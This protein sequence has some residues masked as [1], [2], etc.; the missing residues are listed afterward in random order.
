MPQVATHEQKKDSEGRGKIY[1]PPHKAH[2]MSNLRAYV[3]N[4]KV[5]GESLSDAMDGKSVRDTSV[6]TCDG[7]Q[8]I[9]KTKPKQLA[10][11]L[12]EN[13]APEQV[14]ATMAAIDRICWLLAFAT[15]SQVACYGHSYPDGS[16]H[17]VLKSI[18]RPGQDADPVID[19]A[20]GAA[21]R[22]FVDQTYPQFKALESAR[23][24]NVVIDYMLQAARP[25]LPMECK[26]VFLSVLLE[27]MKHTYGTQQQYAI[28]SGKFV[29]PATN[30]SLSFKVMMTRMFGAVGMAPSLKPLVDLRNEVLHTGVASLTHAQQKLQ[31]DAAT[32]L[33][34]EYLL[35]LLGFNGNFNV[36]PTG[37]SVKTI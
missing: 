19:P 7:H 24:L 22:E 18:H 9:L 20:D 8:F 2:C 21:I 27:N 29:D 35:R 6:F 17:K 13:V 37:G 12:V 32:D 23:S 33:I 16:H 5:Q 28:R 31:Y 3:M 26:L 11:I 36:S 4:Y 1:I 34:R 15:Q 30:A 14:T 25:G 10:E